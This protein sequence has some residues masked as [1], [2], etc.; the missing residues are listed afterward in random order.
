VQGDGAL[1]VRILLTRVVNG[2]PEGSVDSFR[3]TDTPG[4]VVQLVRVA[5]PQTLV[6]VLAAQ[7]EAKRYEPVIE[8]ITDPV[9]P[10][11]T[12]KPIFIALD[13]PLA[14]G[15]GAYVF[16]VGRVNGGQVQLVAY[17]QFVVESGQ[18]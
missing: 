1:Q 7:V 3:P 10:G 12:G 6:F 5:T 8:P 15:P 14:R 11:D 16:V 4:F 13:G 18:G 9:G 2:Q 17:R